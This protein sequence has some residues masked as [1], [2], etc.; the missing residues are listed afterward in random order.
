MEQS[1]LAALEKIKNIFFEEISNWILWLVVFF[2]TGI[3][4]Y[5]SL[6]KEPNLQ[7]VSLISTFTLTFILLFRKNK[8]VLICFL[9]IFFFSFGITTAAWR[10]HNL[11]TEKLTKKIEK[12][13]IY[14]VV[15]KI[16]PSEGKTARLILNVKKV[17]A[18][19]K[20]SVRRLQVMTMNF[21]NDVRVGDFISFYV[22]LSPPSKRLF[23]NSYDFARHAY[24][25]QVGRSGFSFSKIR[26]IESAR[27]DSISSQIENLRLKIFHLLT[28]ELGQ[29]NG[30]VAAALMIGEQRS[31]NKNILD[32]MRYSGLTHILSVSGLHMSL[33]SI[34]CFF[35]IRHLL[36]YSVRFSQQY[37]TKKIA[38]WSSLILSF[39]YLLISGMQVAALRSFIMLA[40]LIVG[41]LI[42]RQHNPKRSVFVAAFLILLFTPEALFHPGFQMSFS[43]VLALVGTYE[44]YSKKV[45][46]GRSNGFSIFNKIKFYFL[47]SIVSSFI[48]GTATSIFVM[49]HFHNY[50][51]YSVLANLLVAPVVSFVIMPSV[52]LAFLL[53]PLPFGICKLAFYALNLGIIFMLKVAKYITALPASNFI[54]PTT[55]IA[56]PLLFTAGL[57]WLCIWE[58]RW[59]AIGLIPMIAS[60]VIIFS[61]SFPD[62]IIDERYKAVLLKSKD[63]KRALLQLSGPKRISKFHKMQWLS[64]FDT[65]QREIINTRL[66]VTRIVK[67]AY[68]IESKLRKLA[69]MCIRKRETK[70]LSE[71]MIK[72]IITQNKVSISR[73]DI[74]EYGA[75]FIYLGQDKIKIE[76]SVDKNISR[77]WT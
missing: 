35:V 54:T 67:G 30:T 76:R 61:T 28:K 40:V 9:P 7:L 43:A 34:I 68:K 72:N 5:F 55:H 38:G 71:L 20:V 69:G 8:M 23:P 65:N 58:R 48:A 73:E 11:S 57:F 77:P 19:E 3:G 14:G 62:I 59:R 25:N 53:M 42:D 52:V 16:F 17:Y 26:I 29:T 60:F 39:G 74:E 24:F 12:A 47:G 13:K 27:D 37:N 41:V 70:E 63:D 44:I 1:F 66:G 49:Y 6:D 56:V 2:A 18:D 33:V 21:N 46:A 31:I 50:S 10:T 64:L 4:F 45:S 22:S 75:H 51:N 32:D 15:E 36:S